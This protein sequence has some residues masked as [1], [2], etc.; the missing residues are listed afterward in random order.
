MQN[1]R[2]PETAGTGNKRAWGET[3]RN[4][5]EGRA[6]RLFVVAFVGFAGLGLLAAASASAGL[7]FLS[8]KIAVQTDKKYG[9]DCFWAPPKGMDYANLPNAIP[10]QKPNLFPDVGSTYFVAQYKLPEG[11]SLTFHGKFGHQRYMSWTMFGRPGELGQ[12]ASAD[13]LRDIYIKPDKGSVNPFR[14]NRKRNAGPRKYTF[15]VVS[16]PI[17][18]HRA[19]NTIYTQTTDPTTRLGMSI[20]NYL[21]DRGRDGTGDAGLPKLVLNLADGTK[22]RG[23]QACAML[24]PIKDASKSTFPAAVWKALVAASSDPVNAPA[25][26][27]PRWEKFWNALYTVAGIFIEDPAERAAK[28]PPT[29]SGGFQANPDTSYLLTPT[30]LKYGSLLTVSGKMPT[31][32]KTLPASKRWTPRKY[33]VR[34]WSLCTGSSAVTGLG[35]DC[36]YDQQVPLSKGRRY[37]LVIGQAKD[38]PPNARPACGYRWIN[39]GKGENYPDPASRDYV[40]TMYMR[41]MA[42]DPGWKQAPQRVKTPGTEKQVMGP[43]FPRSKY[44]TKSEFRKLGCKAK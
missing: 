42:A 1:H 3:L 21:P 35:Y 2:P 25:L 6:R 14:T 17:P 24:D 15:H 30:S 8:H 40:G 34:Y 27:P 11:A 16:G 26:N 29:E 18:A 37:T 4:R 22:L 10:I 5:W 44:W 28:Y 36:V 33:Q 20:R 19:P 39:F 23:Q 13:R 31:F 12:I 9:H 38:R 41:F 43:Y 32:P 7:N